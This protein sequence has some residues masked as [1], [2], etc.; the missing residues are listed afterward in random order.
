MIEE[1][2]LHGVDFFDQLTDAE[3]GALSGCL[4][5]RTLKPTEVI[6]NQG[7]VAK[8][9]FIVLNG[10]IKVLVIDES[11]TDAHEVAE[12]ERGNIFG[13]VALLLGGVRSAT[14]RPGE[15]GAV[16]AE[17]GRIEF[18]QILNAGNSFAYRLLDAISAQLV[19]HTRESVNVLQNTMNSQ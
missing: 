3:R 14:C 15:K 9:C 5:M 12:L 10:T 19:S 16:I 2:Y 11:N 7:D 8:S 1:K 17:L 13:E 18:D 4:T 6:C